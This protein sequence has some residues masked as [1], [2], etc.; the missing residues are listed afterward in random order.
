MR[1]LLNSPVRCLVVRHSVR[2]RADFTAH[3][4][5]TSISAAPELDSNGTGP[6]PLKTGVSDLRLKQRLKRVCIW[7][8]EHVERCT[9][10]TKREVNTQTL[11]SS[12]V[13]PFW[14][15]QRASIQQSNIK[16]LRFHCGNAQNVQKKRETK[17]IR[18]MECTQTIFSWF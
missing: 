14:D 11:W 15:A 10:R 6:V 2:E 16:Y 3:C 9:L 5:H 4:V 17:R 12:A 18:Q 8:I 1:C 7:C 13:A